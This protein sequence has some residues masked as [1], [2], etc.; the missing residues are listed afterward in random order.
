MQRPVL[1]VLIFICSIFFPSFG[2][3]QQSG[4]WTAY[5]ED[6]SIGNAKWIEPESYFTAQL[7]FQTFKN[8]LTDRAIGS[9]Q[10]WLI[11]LPNP[12]G[13]FQSYHVKTNQV[14]PGTL[15]EQFP[16]LATFTGTSTSDPGRKVY[17]DHTQ[18]GMHAMII[19]NGPTVFIDPMYR[20]DN[21]VHVSYFKRDFHHEEE[22]RWSCSFEDDSMSGAQHKLFESIR[23]NIRHKAA[24]MTKEYQLAVATTGEY[25]ALF[26]GTV[27]GGL[28]AVTTA[29]NR[30]TGV[31]ESET[32][33]KLSLVANSNLIIYTDPLA[34]PFTNSGNDLNLVQA[35]IDMQIGDGNYDVGHIFTSSNGGVAGL[36]VVCITG[37]KARGL[38]GLPNPVGDPFYIDYVATK[39]DINSGQLILSMET[40]AHVLV[41][42]EQPAQPMNQAVARP[43]W[44]MQE[45]VETIISKII[46]M[47]ISILPA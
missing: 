12:D 6:L 4:L 22:D 11:D 18:F 9:T 43:L 10:G 26:G 23:R 7:D 20:S 44:R 38:T 47:H 34:D 30:V 28:A 15:K 8:S 16:E 32:G 42:T 2:Y 36:G 33:V 14:L 3:A 1:S 45:F 29:I 25:T 39:S 27:A 35:V 37:S 46:V 17:L 24:L 31:Y 21:R 5:E 13:S 41:E 19:G 40:V